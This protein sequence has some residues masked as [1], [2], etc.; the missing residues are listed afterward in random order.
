MQIAARPA[1]GEEGRNPLPHPRNAGRKWAEHCYFT[2]KN[3]PVQSAAGGKKR[4]FLRGN[5]LPFWR[6]DWPM[7]PS[8]REEGGMGF[9]DCESLHD[10][11]G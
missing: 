11:S 8:R 4:K 9:G 5:S 3:P 6:I 7:P 1:A 2:W 10:R